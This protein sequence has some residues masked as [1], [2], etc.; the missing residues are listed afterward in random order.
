MIMKC[1]LHVLDIQLNPSADCHRPHIEH[2]GHPMMNESNY[3]YTMSSLLLVS[4]HPLAQQLH[5]LQSVPS[6][7]TS[8]NG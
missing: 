5:S 2:L 3:E 1:Y 7:Q 8:V 6:T 4:L